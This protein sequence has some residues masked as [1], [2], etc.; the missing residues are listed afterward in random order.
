M[1][2]ICFYLAGFIQ[3][4][5]GRA[6]SIIG[7]ELNKNPNYNITALCHSNLGK[8]NI[9]HTDFD[10]TYL[11][12]K[13]IPVGSAILKDNYLKKVS[14]YLINNDIDLLIVCDELFYPPA[15]IAGRKIKVLCWF[16]TSPAVSS[17]YRFQKSVKLFGFLF[18][19]GIIALTKYTQNSIKKTFKRKP[20]Y[21]IYNPLDDALFYHNVSYNPDTEKIISVGRLSYP[22]NFDRIV[23]LAEN[24]KQ[25]FPKLEWHIYGEGEERKH[26]E[27]LI[28]EKNLEK[29]VKLMGQCS[30]LYEKYGEYSA[31]VNTSRYEGFP[32]TL[33]EASACGLPMVSFDILTGPSEI[34]ADGENGFLCQNNNEEQMA[35]SIAKMFSC[36]NLRITMSENSRKTALKY[37]LSTII[38]QWNSML[39]NYI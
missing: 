21:Q 24:L 9:Y 30:N 26:L 6:V 4:G 12:N 13:R 19:K 35:E 29:T 31:I 11:Y 16:H 15:I 20:I 37:K 7:N 10:V 17:D 22:K 3:G 27:Q 34:I 25:Q 39:E 23:S 38:A 18:S 1:S 8:E 14:D 33:I 32:M 2:N 5:I 36:R 28:S